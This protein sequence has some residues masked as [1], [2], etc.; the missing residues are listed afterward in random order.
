[1]KKEK[2]EQSVA[3]HREADARLIREKCLTVL[4]ND[5]LLTNATGVKAVTEAGKLLA[6]LQHLLQVDKQV[7]KEKAKKEQKKKEE[8]LSAE[9]KKRLDA[10]FNE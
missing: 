6:R 7:I 8:Q 10:I 5:D 9:D 2:K 3:T 1:M 4:E